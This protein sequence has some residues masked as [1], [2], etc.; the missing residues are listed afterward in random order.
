MLRARLL[1]SLLLILAPVMARAD[2]ADPA[3]ADVLFREGRR[4][5]DAGN[6]ALACPKFEES[7]RL[8][9]APG[10]LLN[11]ADC[12]ENRGQLTRAWQH[13]QQ[14]TDELPATDERRPIAIARARAL[15]TRAP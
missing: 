9:P 4:D 12:E 6:Y 7:F 10:T 15:E 2:G 1:P 13:F 14:L 3:A 11:L 5:A 8:D